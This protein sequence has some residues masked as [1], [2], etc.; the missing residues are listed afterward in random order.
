MLRLVSASLARSITHSNVGAQIS[1]LSLR[2]REPA[3]SLLLVPTLLRENTV[4][5]L[6]LTSV[7]KDDIVE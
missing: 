3:S 1:S 2:E 4:E 7:I 6:F 5:G